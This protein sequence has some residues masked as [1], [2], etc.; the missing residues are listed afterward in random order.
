MTTCQMWQ[1]LIGS[2]YHST[3]KTSSISYHDVVGNSYRFDPSY[4][5]SEATKV[6]LALGSL[7]YDTTDV[8]SSSDKVFIGNIFSRVFVKDPKHGLPYLAASDTVLAN[9]DTGYYLSKKQ[10]SKLSYLM[11]HKDWILVTCSGTL[12][13]VTYTNEVFE[14]R[15]ATHDLIR[16]VPNDKEI[17][18]GC[19]FA[20]LSGKYGYYQLTQSQ[21]GG[22]VKHINAEHAKSI[23][24]PKFPMAFQTSIDALIKDAARLREESI[25]AL[26]RA[27]QLIE[28]HFPSEFTDYN[29]GS[30]SF[31]TVFNSQIHRLEASYHLSSG[32]QY[33]DYIKSHFSW[34]TLGDATCAIWRPDI[35]K[36]MYV[37]DGISFLGG[38]DLFLSIPDSKK[39]LSRKAPNVDD[40]LIQEGWI[41]LPRSG[42]IG[43]VVY[44]NEQHAQKLVSEDVIRIIPNNVLRGGYTFAFLSSRIG[45]ALIQRPIFGSVIQHVEPP[46][47]S[48]IPIPV[49]EENEMEQVALLA[50]KYRI[51]WGKAAKKE[52]EAITLV[53]QEIEKRSS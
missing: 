41:L 35:V 3:M 30:V 25:G 28:S 21:F 7:P 8:A 22:V 16:I 31:S 24:V 1:L 50:E 9:L 40:Y 32:R 18:R 20:F 45:K 47:L 34:R 12:G 13:N 38:T 33:E 15:I 19:L 27:H 39:K 52:L 26:K 53:E 48:V 51:C 17:L 29:T 36:R 42:T 2:F 4:H 5:L 46:L 10:A 23:I 14:N 6:R 43:D 37:K 11:L 44:T 49:F